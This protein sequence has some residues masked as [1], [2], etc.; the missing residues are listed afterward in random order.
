[1]RSLLRCKKGSLSNNDEASAMEAC[2]KFH[3]GKTCPGHIPGFS[4]NHVVIHK[5][6][7]VD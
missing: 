7:K 5:K 1:M 3:V 4:S 2:D 6:H